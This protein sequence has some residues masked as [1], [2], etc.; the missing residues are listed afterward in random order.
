MDHTT[1]VDKVVFGFM[2]LVKPIL[3]FLSL[4]WQ[5]RLK[6]AFSEYQEVERIKKEHPEDVSAVM[7]D[8]VK[9]YLKVTRA[10]GVGFLKQVYKIL[11]I[12]NATN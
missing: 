2:P 9:G 1:Y 11:Y 5:G 6:R 12:Q 3:S 8:R 10:F 7:N 4:Y